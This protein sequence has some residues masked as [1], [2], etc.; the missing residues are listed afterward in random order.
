MKSLQPE[1]ESEDESGNRI[2]HSGTPL[3]KV[4]CPLRRIYI[5][6]NDQKQKPTFTVAPGAGP[7]LMHHDLLLQTP[8]TIMTAQSRS[9]R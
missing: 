7:N 6:G 8:I 1:D 9:L 5:S 2:L 4:D 3:M